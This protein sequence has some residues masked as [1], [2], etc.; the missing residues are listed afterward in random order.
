MRQFKEVAT[1][2]GKIGRADTAT[3]PAPYAMA[4]TIVRLRPR[5]EWPKQP[6]TRWYSTLGAAGPAPRCWGWSGPTSRRATTAELVDRLDKA[7]RLPGWINAWT[8]PARARMDMMATGLRTPVGHAH[9]RPGSDAAGRARRGGAR[10]AGRLP[11]TR[12]AV[13]ESLGGETWLGL[14]TDPAALARHDV[15]PAAVRATAELLVTGG[16]IGELAQPDGRPLRVRVLPEPR[17]VT[18]ARRRRS[19]ARRHRSRAGGAA[20][21]A[22]GQPVPLGLLGRAVYV[23]GRR[24]CAPSAA[25]CARTSTSISRRRRSAGY[26][27]RARRD[28]AAAIGSGEFVSQPGERIEWAGQYELLQARGSGACAGSFRWSRSR[29]WACSFCSSA[30]SPRR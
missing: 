11:G 23:R 1:V 6:R 21:D 14:D 25:S 22:R 16:Q 2:F 28:V 12:S 26:V 5:S 20:G 17:D 30:A 4:E 19:A 29:C 24:C 3:D 13:F 9:R 7:T 27:E 8:A 10:P 15:D 18:A